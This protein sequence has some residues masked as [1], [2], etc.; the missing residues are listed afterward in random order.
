MRPDPAIG[1]LLQ[2]N[3]HPERG[4]G[5]AG[6]PDRLHRE[7]TVKEPTG[8]GAAQT[9][10]VQD[11]GRQRAEPAE[12]TG[13]HAGQCQTIVVQRQGLQLAQ[14]VEDP[15]G[16]GGQLVP[17]Q[18]QRGQVAEGSEQPRGQRLQLVPAQRQAAQLG[19][20]GEQPCG[21][22]LQLV[23][24]Q[25]QGDQL[26][27][28]G[29]QPRGQRL[30]LVIVQRQGAQ[31]AQP[32][33]QPRGQRL[34][35]VLVQLQSRQ[36]AEVGEVAAPEH[37][38]PRIGQVQRR[39]PAQVDRGHQP[40]IGRGDQRQKGVAHRRR[41]A[42][43][44]RA[45]HDD[46]EHEAAGVAHVVGGRPGVDARRGDGRRRAGQ[47][48]RSEVDGQPVGQDGAAQR[49]DQAAA[50]A[51][52]R[53]GHR[54]MLPDDIELR[55]HRHRAEHRDIVVDH[56]DGEG[57]GIDRVAG[58]R[59]GEHIDVVGVVGVVLRAHGD[60]LPHVPVRGGKD[61]VGTEQED[62]SGVFA[63]RLGTVDP[64]DTDGPGGSGV[65]Q[66]GIG[67]PAAFR[68]GEGRGIEHHPCRRRRRGQ[69]ESGILPRHRRL[70]G[71]LRGDALG[72]QEPGTVELD[73]GCPLAGAAERRAGA[74]SRPNGHGAGRSGHAGRRPGHLHVQWGGL[75]NHRLR[76]TIPQ[77]LQPDGQREPPGRDTVPSQRERTQRANPVKQPRGQIGEPVPGQRQLRQGTQP[78]E[79]AS[80]QMGKL[81]V[82]QRQG[83]Q[84]GQAVEVPD[85]Q[86][87][88]GHAGDRQHANPAQT[89]RGDRRAGGHADRT[90][91]R[92]A[93]RRGA[94][95]DGG[96]LHLDGE[97]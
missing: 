71:G 31:P 87:A 48:T 79:D 68:N 56:P 16:Q 64:L 1:L 76:L 60:R 53:Q 37:G 13:G 58:D 93:Y 17:V 73:D 65:Q 50:A 20:I 42:T 4:T 85:P 69:L 90:H 15:V 80:G 83:R 41:A 62:L 91:Q 25:R 81:Q 84:G 23:P 39:D 52:F 74:L 51:G 40:A 59:M 11:Q 28:P 12:D 10:A 78:A 70:A 57:R 66:H 18:R 3:P 47:G 82:I 63:I 5:V 89:V 26:G 19:Q 49:V 96:A 92:V 75:R 67:R 61:R 54:Q 34:Q 72:E 44:G 29:E 97:G 55:P 33:E 6:H 38:Q 94:A 32:G 24:V 46:G 77:S 86:G 30:Q 43:E 8:Q 2:L 95:T 45:S 36:P 21:Q 88:D 35:P 9:V 14:I 27:Q 22:R 7:Q